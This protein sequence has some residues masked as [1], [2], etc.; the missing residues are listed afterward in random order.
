MK[1]EVEITI[2]AIRKKLKSTT[3]AYDKLKL[4][5]ELNRLKILLQQEKQSA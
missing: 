2:R 3:N 1:T 4:R 5:N